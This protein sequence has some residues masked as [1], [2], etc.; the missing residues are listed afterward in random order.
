MNL[1]FKFSSDS[2]NLNEN[3]KEEKIKVIKKGG[4]FIYKPKLSIIINKNNYEVNN[5]F[6]TQEELYRLGN[7][8]KITVLNIIPPFNHLKNYFDQIIEIMK[9]L[10]LPIYWETPSNMTVSMSTIK[11]ISKQIKTNL[12]KKA[13]PI[14]ILIPTDQM[15]YKQIKT[16]F[17]PNFI[18]SLDA[19]NIHLLIKNIED[20]K[21]I[22]LIY[23]QSMI[24]L[25]V[26]AVI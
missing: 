6:L 4:F 22:K 9:H 25:L 26:I 19:S 12:I 18:H 20:L 13:K 23:I 8:L 17:M 10:D 7:Y 16:G 5:L 3:N 11:M 1:D 24:V 14:S 2:I 15:D 21:L